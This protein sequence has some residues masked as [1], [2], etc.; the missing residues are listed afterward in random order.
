MSTNVAH[1]EQLPRRHGPAFGH[2]GPPPVAERQE[3]PGPL[4]RTTEATLAVAIVLPVVAVYAAFAYGV[5]RAL[6]MS[7]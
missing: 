7:F 2:E 4:D 5:Y 1:G 3:S 6:T